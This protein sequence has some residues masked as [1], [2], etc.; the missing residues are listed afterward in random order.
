[1]RS[2]WRPAFQPKHFGKRTVKVK[3]QQRYQM[4]RTS[5]KGNLRTLKTAVDFS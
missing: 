5:R 3:F 4:G 2:S 1:V